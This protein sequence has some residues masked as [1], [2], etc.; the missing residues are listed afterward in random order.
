[1]SE[2]CRMSFSVSFAKA[3]PTLEAALLEPRSILCARRTLR[4]HWRSPGGV[5]VEAVTY[6][7]LPLR[8]VLIEDHQAL[9]EGLELLL[10]REGCEVVGTAGTAAE[11][12][13]LVERR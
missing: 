10:S 1:M 8:L 3:F 7:V 9:R 2:S 11:G 4:R 13:A 12:R 5:R 6:P